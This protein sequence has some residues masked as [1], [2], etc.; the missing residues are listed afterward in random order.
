MG[1]EVEVVEREER[2]RP[3]AS[4]VERLH[5][6]N[7]KAKRLLNWSPEFAGRD[8]FKNGL[9]KTAV[10]FKDASNLARYRIGS[11]TL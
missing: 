1:V 8:G 6:S 10:W 3:A 2:Q 4:E 7:A 5:A 9:E 11:Y